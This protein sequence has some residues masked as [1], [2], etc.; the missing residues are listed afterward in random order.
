MGLKIGKIY[1]SKFYLVSS[2]S[3][4]EIKKMMSFSYWKPKTFCSNELEAKLFVQYNSFGYPNIRTI[5]PMVK[6]IVLEVK[7]KYVKMLCEG[8]VG[9]IVFS[10]KHGLEKVI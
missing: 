7:G 3:F 1:R 4:E 6:M 2:S 5:E 8:K 9:W 10:E